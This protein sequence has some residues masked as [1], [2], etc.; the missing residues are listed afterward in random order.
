MK[1]LNTLN[2]I[3]DIYPNGN[4]DLKH[5]QSYIEKILPGHSNLFINDMNDMIK[6]GKCNFEHDFLP[7]L[8]RVYSHEQEVNQAIQSFHK[9]VKNIEEKMIEKFNK[10]I[11]ADIIL[12]LGLCNGA[13]WVVKVEDRQTILLGIEKIIELEWFDVQSMVGLIYHELG[14][15]YQM[16]YG[17]LERKIV[18]LP[19]QFIWQLFTEGVAMVF[20]QILMDDSSFFHQDRNGWL[21]WCEEH[22]DQIKIDFCL[23]LETMTDANQR[24]FGDWVEY[25]KHSDVGYYLGSKF[26]WFL[27]KQYKFDEIILLDIEEVVKL[28]NR[29]ISNLKEKI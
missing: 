21:V 20:E 12:Y 14:H 18:R 3:Q 23:D 2:L 9:V 17:I 15:I 29:F 1:I 8:N 6:T 10:S 13:G 28:F 19:E 26:I 7:V 5:W 16:Q 22:N 11:E 24:Y 27:S 25:Q 4:F